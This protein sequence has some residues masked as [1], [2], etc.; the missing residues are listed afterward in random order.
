L[1]FPF[2]TICFIEIPPHGSPERDWLVSMFSGSGEAYELPAFLWF[3]TSRSVSSFC[4]LI[5][6]PAY[7]LAH[8]QH[9]RS[10]I[11]H[12]TFSVPACFVSYA[13]PRDP[14]HQTNCQIP[15]LENVR[16]RLK[17]RP[18]SMPDA[19]NWN[20]DLV[21]SFYPSHRFGVTELR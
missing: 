17:I 2:S 14:S 16:L 11:T 7:L 21:T 15:Y 19:E 12:E 1:I 10:L 3:S 20:V 9:L 18:W 6:S 4:S 5:L 13:S 8:L